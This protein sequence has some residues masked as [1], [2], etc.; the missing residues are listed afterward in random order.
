MPSYYVKP[1]EMFGYPCNR[2]TAFLC[3]IRDDAYDP[4]QDAAEAW[5][6]ATQMPA[7]STA[8]KCRRPYCV[9]VA[10]ENDA[11]VDVAVCV[12][13]CPSTGAVNASTG[14]PDGCHESCISCA[15]YESNPTF[16]DDVGDCN[17][18]V[19]PE[20]S[21]LEYC[22]AYEQMAKD[23]DE[24][25]RAYTDAWAWYI[26]QYRINRY[27]DR[28]KI[29]AASL[30][31]AAMATG[32]KTMIEVSHEGRTVYLARDVNGEQGWVVDSDGRGMW[33]V[34][35]EPADMRAVLERGTWRR[36]DND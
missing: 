1:I 12:H 22:S 7:A 4:V 3:T 26:I 31:R 25:V 16:Y 23:V 8:W 5:A 30:C 20:C 32:D 6:K 18:H 14:K 9:D 15:H 11:G 35:E 34:R 27:D 28:D 19:L 24:V 10:V 2:E 29:V 21:D 13:I 33:P 17:L 36:S